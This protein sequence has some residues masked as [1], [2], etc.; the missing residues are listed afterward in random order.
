MIDFRYYVVAITAIFAAL[1]AGLF[2]GS[3]LTMSETAK[4]QQELIV[5]SIKKD[6]ENLRKEIG[7]KNRELEIYREYQKR[8]QKWL[9][10]DSLLNNNIAIVYFE[11]IEK[12]R[13]YKSLKDELL[14]A[15]AKILEVSITSEPTET[16]ALSKLV[17]AL[18]SPDASEKLNKLTEESA[19]FS[20]TGEVGQVQ[21]I[22]L[23]LDKKILSLAKDDPDFK[24]LPV[25]R[26]VS[27]NLDNA[28]EFME[29]APKDST[30]V[31]YDGDPYDPEALILSFNSF[32][33]IFGE[34]ING[35]SVIPEAQK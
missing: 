32:N 16:T 14:S 23:L 30:C 22:L 1:I 21:Q 31:I 24:E 34:G 20:Y 25:L 13:N 9:V 28:K 11:G 35:T 19:V 27:F 3:S 17:K 10:K 5:K 12:D 4:K 26:A 6:I 33:G 15:G 2:L 7:E 29:I 18:F 8:A